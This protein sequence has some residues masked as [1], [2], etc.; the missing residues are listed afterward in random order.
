[1]LLAALD[2]I[3][4]DGPWLAGEEALSLADLHGAPMIDYAPPK[5][6]EGLAMLKR[7]SPTLR[8]GGRRWPIGW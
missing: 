5:L 2:A 3:M 6:P 1:M 4:E 8:P 7:F